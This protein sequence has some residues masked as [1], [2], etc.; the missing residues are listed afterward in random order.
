MRAPHHHPRRLTLAGLAVL[1]ALGSTAAL[2]ADQTPVVVAD[3]AD[4][5]PGAPDL[6][7]VAASR[8]AEHGVRVA[9]SLAGE[10]TPAD[11]LT[12]ADDAG[13]PGSICVR[14]WTTSTPRTTPPDLL[15][16][17]T[18]QPGGTA[19]RTTVTREVPGGLPATAGT[20]KLTRPSRRS[21]VLRL[22]GSLFGTA[23]RVR[24]AA[25][26]TKPGCPRLSCVD[27]AP[28][29]GEVKALRLR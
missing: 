14:L 1:G 8:T 11:L 18:A 13:P 24:F 22:P 6:K 16:C 29:R 19:F 26:A 15:A 25:E 17:V 5:R 23:R 2:A 27:L 20:A 21:L 7:R 3:H 10:L 9:I 28:D 12:E 4:A